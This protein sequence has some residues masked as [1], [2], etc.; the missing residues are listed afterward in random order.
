MI[1]PWCFVENSGLDILPPVDL[2]EN[3]HCAPGVGCAAATADTLP[4]GGV[5]EFRE[6][7]SVHLSGGSDDALDGGL[8][9]ING[10]DIWPYTNLYP[11]GI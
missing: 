8:Y 9:S 6:G 5:E 7:A 1:H 3:R 11:L 10:G 2:R 4:Q